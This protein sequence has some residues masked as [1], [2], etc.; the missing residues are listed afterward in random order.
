MPKSTRKI[1]AAKP[2]KDFPLTPH[3]SGKWHKKIH[4]KLHSFGSTK[5][6]P[7][8][9]KALGKWLEEKDDFLAGRTPRPKAEGLTVR[10]IRKARYEQAPKM[11]T[12]DELRGLIDA[13]GVP[14]RAM[15]LLGLNAAL[16]NQDVG[17]LPMK[18]LDLKA[19]WLDYPRPK[20]GVP[21]RCPFWKETVEAIQ[22]AIGKR[23]APKNPEHTDWVF[24]TKYGDSW[25]GLMKRGTGTATNSGCALA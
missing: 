16:G 5:A 21:R 17:T 20:T 9:Q 3:P 8:G 4:G 12:A 2:H 25:A 18:A 7:N 19:G 13:A 11:F 6:D 22:E 1:R 24:V 15:I 10:T 14:M 23:P